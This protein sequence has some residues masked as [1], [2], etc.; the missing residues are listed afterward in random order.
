MNGCIVYMVNDEQ[1]YDSR[2]PTFAILVISRIM[3]RRESINCWVQIDGMASGSS[4]EQKLNYKGGAPCS[5]R[6]SKLLD[7]VCSVKSTWARRKPSG[8]CLKWAQENTRP[9]IMHCYQQHG[10]GVFTWWAKAQSAP[11]TGKVV[12]TNRPTQAVL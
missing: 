6:K 7:E 4:V 11:A 2:T 5:R 10:S 3:A 9:N 1:R 8:H 12:S